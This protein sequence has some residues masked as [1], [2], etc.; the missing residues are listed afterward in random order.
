M[1]VAA[2]YAGFWRRLAAWF[3]D[4][5]LFGLLLALL[6]R[7][8]ALGEGVGMMMGEGRLLVYGHFNLLDNLLALVLTVALWVRFMGTPGKLLLGCQVVDA[9]SGR[10]LGVGQAVLRYFGYLLSLLPFGL[11]FLWIAFDRRKQGFHDKLA[12]TVVLREHL[13][14]DEGEA[15]KSLEQLMREAR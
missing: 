2:R 4:T 13:C 1:Q 3:I 10:P 15:G 14:W 7:L 11:G 5:V 8:L 6:H 12:K 9:R